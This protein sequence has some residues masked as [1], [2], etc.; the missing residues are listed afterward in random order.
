[1]KVLIA[2][3]DP[4]TCRMLEVMLRSWGYEAVVASN[5]KEAMEVLM[6]QDSPQLAVLDWLMP[7]I[8]GIEVC[9]RV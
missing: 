1:M 8:D 3:D 7:E 4:V 9:R 5:G 2:E 6:S